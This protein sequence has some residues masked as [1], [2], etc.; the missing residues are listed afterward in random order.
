MNLIH[1]DS[2]WIAKHIVEGQGALFFNEPDTEYRFQTDFEAEGSAVFVTNS[3]IYANPNNYQITFG[4]DSTRDGTVGIF[5]FA[6]RSHDSVVLGRDANNFSKT[7]AP[8]WNKTDTTIKNGR[9]VHG[10]AGKW[11]TCIGGQY[12]SKGLTLDNLYLEV[13]GQDGMCINTGTEKFWT[14][15]TNTHA[16][17]HSTSTISRHQ[18]PACIKTGQL[19]ARRCILIGGNSGFAVG[20]E[21][22]ISQCLIRHAGWATN[23]YGLHLGE[24]NTEA[25]ENLILPSNGRSVLI[26]G[27]RKHKVHRNLMTT[28]EKF[29]AEYPV[30]RGIR[31][32]CFRL[33]YN[34]SG[35]TFSDNRCLAIGGGEHRGAVYGA[36]ISQ[37]EAYLDLDEPP[38]N[39][40]K[41]TN[42]E[43]RTVLISQ[44]NK[45]QFAKAISLEGLGTPEQFASTVIDGNR[46]ASNQYLLSLSGSE[47]GCYHERMAGNSFE[48]GSGHGG[49]LWFLNALSDPIFDFKYP[50]TN[51][52]VNF[53]LLEQIKDEVSEEVKVLIAN[54][55][56][57]VGNRSTFFGGSWTRDSKI[58]LIDSQFREDVGT[59]AD[60]VTGATEGEIDIKIGHSVVWG[61]ATSD[62]IDHSLVKAAGRDEPVVRVGWVVEPEPV[63]DPEPEPEPEPPPEVE[64]PST[65]VV[66]QSITDLKTMNKSAFSPMQERDLRFALLHLEEILR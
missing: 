34:A 6:K 32:P 36:R 39:R 60:D 12:V 66:R 2:D 50:D 31:S 64:P 19:F 10:G 47:G 3:R 16:V 41:I 15:L 65:E 28:Y 5:P 37:L 46:F 42:N 61:G 38:E 9:I 27:G 52:Y 29:N 51:S 13:S 30:E 62:V 23:G 4:L 57:W 53:A 1:V 33:R 44:L 18:L 58:T 43:F 54:V 55:T 56:A 40:N 8:N 35:N 25:Y 24:E 45:K 63:P 59:D 7:A 22:D 14:T 26:G 48:W 17:N 11:A 20:S 21:S 49:Y